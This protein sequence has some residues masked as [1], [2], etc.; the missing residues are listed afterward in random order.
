MEFASLLGGGLLGGIGGFFS[1]RSR[2]K[3]LERFRQQQQEGIADARRITEERVAAVTGNPLIQAATNF[4]QE[5]FAGD[6]GPLAEQ[7]KKRLQVAQES[8][9]LRRS[10]ASAVAEA[11]SLAAFRQQFLANLLP[12]A[13]NFGTLGERFRQG[14]LQQELPI[15]IG[16]RTGAPIP[17]ISQPNLQLMDPAGFDPISSIFSQG[18]QGAIGG[19]QVG[20][21]F[22]RINQQNSFLEELRR[23]PSGGGGF[24]GGGGIAS[25]LG[26]FF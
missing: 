20:S 21:E 25:A 16:S 23:R 10:T 22:N 12:Q 15:N 13:E 6:G 9:G 18:T 24:G 3:A 1:A 26:A 8:R 17:G 14:I 11:S 4:I 19:F 7:F 2:R 5:S